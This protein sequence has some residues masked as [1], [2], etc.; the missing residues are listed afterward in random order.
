VYT[1]LR[2]LF[3]DV[4]CAKPTTSRNAS[5]ESFAVCR[6]FGHG[7]LEMNKCLNLVL[8]GGWDEEFSG[9]GG[10]RE[11]PRQEVVSSSVTFVSCEKLRGLTG[12]AFFIFFRQVLPIGR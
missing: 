11:Y 9:L 7:K 10:S 8:E 3:D 4:Q 1:R 2:F 6:G 5:V 12:E